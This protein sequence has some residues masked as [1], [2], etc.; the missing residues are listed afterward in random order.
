MSESRFHRLGPVREILLISLSCIGDVLLTTPVM[1]VLK[2]NFPDARLTVL[3]G[4]TS[5]ELMQAHEL[6]DRALVFD[7]KDVH[8]GMAG[9]A[10][11]VRMLWQYRFD[12]VVDLRNSA[13]PYVLRTRKRITSHQAHMRNRDAQGRHAIDRH[14]DVLR[15]YGFPITTRRMLITV[16]DEVAARVTQMMA[17]RGL[18]D[19]PVFGIYPGA[20]SPYKQYPSPLFKEAVAQLGAL[21][22]DAKF[23]LVGGPDDARAAATV[24]EAAPGRCA[25]FSGKINI[26]E[27][28][29][30]IRRCNLFISNDSGPMHIASALDVPTVAI[31]GPTDAHRYGPRCNVSRIVWRREACNP[32]K[33]PECG[34]DSCIGSIP[35]AD[36][37]S[38]AAEVLNGPSQDPAGKKNLA[39]LSVVIVS[40]KTRDLLDKCL[41]SVVNRPTELTLQVIVV[42]NNSGDGTVEMVRDKYPAVTLIDNKDNTGYSVANNQ[43]VRASG[44]RH[45]LLLNPDTESNPSAL[46]AMVKF[47]DRHETV[48][49]VGV[50]LLNTDGS[51]QESH[52]NFPAPMSRYVENMKWYP[53]VSQKLL[54]LSPSGPCIREHGARRVDIIKGACLM[55][56]GEA[57]ERVGLLDENSFLYADDI[58]WCMRARRSGWDAY[59]LSNQT[60]LH[61]GWASTSQET[62]LT[63]VSSR[64]S[65]MLLYRKH[66][67]ALF[68]SFWTL[69]IFLEILYKYLLNG[70]RVKSGRADRAAQDKFKAYR[71]LINEDILKRTDPGEA[72]GR[73]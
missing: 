23:V 35:P 47:L 25:D 5:H 17:D 28:A 49:A 7:N 16:P 27:T 58:D 38:A 4:G 2:D 45:V 41:D 33:T 56:R 39:D 67:P 71:D 42:D 48:G 44:A 22:P 63:I 3:A 8:K 20:G 11:L 18:R 24:A 26:L 66:Y 70:L 37:V 50:Q 13:I 64:R 52:F 21:Y 72:H 55:C 43:G 61:H 65:A 54:R 30:V 29:A 12:L 15:L 9:K 6:V 32:C 60:L 36:I 68:V 40:Y 10:R 59:L 57:L 46:E 1:R 19:C 73:K 34:H 51:L 69:F 62:Y 31:F 14:L 53:E